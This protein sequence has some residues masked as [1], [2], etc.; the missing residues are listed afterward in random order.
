LEKT[1]F[2]K[3]ETGKEISCHHAIHIQ[4]ASVLVA[5]LIFPSHRSLS[6]EQNNHISDVIDNKS[7]RIIGTVIINTFPQK[8]LELNCT[9]DDTNQ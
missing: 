3:K 1:N 7:G 5:P 6:T 9:D 4:S 8:D 2:R